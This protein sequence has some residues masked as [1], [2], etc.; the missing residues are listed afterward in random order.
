MFYGPF[1]VGTVLNT[2][3]DFR[4]SSKVSPSMWTSEGPIPEAEMA[5]DVSCCPSGQVSVLD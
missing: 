1:V 2:D 5:E 4:R 3:F